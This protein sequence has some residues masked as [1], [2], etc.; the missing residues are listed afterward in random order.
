MHGALNQAALRASAWCITS[1]RK[2]SFGF[3]CADVSGL[4]CPGTGSARPGFRVLPLNIAEPTRV[5]FSPDSRTVARA[6]WHALSVVRGA[7]SAA[8]LRPGCT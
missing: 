1:D 8:Q 2:S 4:T 6:V 7:M 5:L 3:A